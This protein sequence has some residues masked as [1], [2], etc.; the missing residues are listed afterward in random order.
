MNVSTKG[1]ICPTLGEIICLFDE[2]N[3]CS[4]QAFNVGHSSDNSFHDNEVYQDNSSENHGAWF[5]DRED[6]TMNKNIN[7]GDPTLQG[8]QVG[9]RNFH[10]V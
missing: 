10:Y 9:S 6:E 5:F 8:H 1:E 2:D 3:Q 4:R 7:F